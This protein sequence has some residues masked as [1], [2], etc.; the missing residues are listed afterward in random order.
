MAQLYVL[1]FPN[2]KSYVG[3]TCEAVA[4]RY[5]RHFVNAFLN[6]SRCALHRAMRKHGVPRVVPIMEGSIEEMKEHEVALI[7][8]LGTL[9]P[10]GYNMTKGGDGVWGLRHSEESCKRMSKSQRGK[11]KSDEHRRRL[12]ESGRMISEE[13]RRRIAD[14]LKGRQFSNEHRRRLAESM[15]GKKLSDEHRRKLAEA[16]KGRKHSEET[17]RRIA[18]ALTGRQFSDEHRRAIAEANRRRKQA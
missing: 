15:R 16:G 1:A 14:A 12:S 8:H 7:A 11:R 3:I 13:T 9:A 17:R 5:E 4:R 2:G 18:E 6:G 10:N